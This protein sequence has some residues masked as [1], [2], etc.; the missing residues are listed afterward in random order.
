MALIISGTLIAL[1]DIIPWWLPLVN[2]NHRRHIILY[3]LE[4][5]Q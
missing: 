5:L 1:E 3:T 2:N 4:P